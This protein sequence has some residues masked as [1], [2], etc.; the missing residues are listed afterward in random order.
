VA[1]VRPLYK[2]ANLAL[3]PT[4]ESAGTNIKVLEAMAMERA[5][6]STSSGCAGLGLAHG[7]TIWIADGAGAFAQGIARLIGDEALRHA[8]A[9]QAREHAEK[10][11]SWKGLGAKQ[12]QLW[13]RYQPPPLRIDSGDERHL[14]AIATI[15]EGS[16]GSAQWS[17][18]DY[19]GY[20]LLIAS[21]LEETIGFAVIRHLPPNEHEILDL[22]VAPNWRRQG[23]AWR[24]LQAATKQ[25]PGEMFLEVRESNE[26]AKRLY[27]S[28]GFE[29]AGKRPEYYRNPDE[30]GIVM[31][32][33]TC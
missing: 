29:I 13:A 18:A 21:Y 22:A 8:I 5:V 19:L 2:E 20:D 14:A 1:D 24:L 12:R 31:R 30:A 26:P 23:V 10:H 6:A 9:R 11:Y 17:P 7:E 33:R 4:L 25:F 28:A 16:P 32:L 15:Q 3:V 27:E